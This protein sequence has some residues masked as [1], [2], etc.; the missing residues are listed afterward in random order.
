M[1]GAYTLGQ[2]KMEMYLAVIKVLERGDSMAQQQ[3]M[4]KTGISFPLSKEFFN[5]L[6]GLDIISEKTIGPK[7]EYFITKK[8]HMLCDY[9]GLND[10]NSIFSGTGIFRIG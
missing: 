7:V 4:R 10:D 6:V 2:S 9:F 1:K 8:G 3:I 5:F